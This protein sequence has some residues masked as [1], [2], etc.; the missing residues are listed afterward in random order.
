MMSQVEVRTRSLSDVYERSNVAVFEPA[1]FE[2]VEKDDKWIEAMK[3]ELRMIE[4]N[5]TWE[6]VDIPQHRKVIGVKWVYRTKLNADGSINKYKAR[7][8]VKGYSQVF[9]V[10]FSETFAPVAHLDTIRM[11]LA[12]IAQK[13]WKTYQLDVKSIFLNGYLQEEIYVDQ[14]EGF[15]VKGQEEK[16]YLLKKALYGLKQAPRA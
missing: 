2:E 5:D 7:L 14:P 13:G 12:L 4:K 6:L 15:Q 10:D 1:E 9:G 8:V 3:E 11:L 16:V